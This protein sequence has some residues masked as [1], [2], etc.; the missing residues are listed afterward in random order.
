MIAAVY[1]RHSY[2]AVLGL[3]LATVDVR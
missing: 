3:C 1:A 2:D